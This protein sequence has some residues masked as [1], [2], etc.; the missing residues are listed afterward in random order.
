MST[1]VPKPGQVDKKWWVVDAKDQVLGRLA[2][3]V[4]NLLTGKLKPT[5]VPYMDVGDHVIVVNAGKV[6]LTGRKL[7]QKVYHRHTGYPGGLKSVSV[8]D[9]INKRPDRVIEMAVKG[10]LPKN[11][12]GRAMGLKLKVYDGESHPHQAQRPQVS[13]LE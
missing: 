10:M 6:K 2:S 7:E 3:H 11:K 9:L 1:F 13:V 4:A 8:R 12:L 5:W